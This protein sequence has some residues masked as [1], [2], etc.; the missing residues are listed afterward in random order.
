MKK[1]LIVSAGLAAVLLTGSYF[2]FFRSAKTDAGPTN[3]P[4]SVASTVPSTTSAPIA[5]L[6]STTVSNSFKGASNV[7]A[8]AKVRPQT[9]EFDINVNPYAAA[10]QEPGK[11]KRA[12]D[13]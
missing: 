13:A 6:I 4:A 11:S 5:A 2:A 3:T 9:R 1:R 7:A 8:Q 10:L 12:W